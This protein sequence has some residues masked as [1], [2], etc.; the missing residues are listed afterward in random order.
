MYCSWPLF[1][2]REQTGFPQF[3]ICQQVESSSC[4]KGGKHTLVVLSP[5]PL[6]DKKRETLLSWLYNERVEKDKLLTE[7]LGNVYQ[8]EA[9]T[10]CFLR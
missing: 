10:E 9:S 5:G 4:A 7:L 3:F 1:G 8:T 2:Y 6:Q